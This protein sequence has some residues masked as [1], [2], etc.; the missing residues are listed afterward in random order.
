MPKVAMIETAVDEVMTPIKN[1]NA[2]S[3][4]ITSMMIR[5]PM[6][7][8]PCRTPVFHARIV[9]TASIR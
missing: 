1:E 2:I 6:K 4:A 3:V 8:R 9:P 7:K 5:P